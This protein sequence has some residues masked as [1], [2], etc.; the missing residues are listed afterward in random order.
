MKKVVLGAITAALLAI[1][2]TAAPASAGTSTA[3]G[4]PLEK[5]QDCAAA[6]AYGLRNALNGTPQPG[7]C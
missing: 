2:V 4:D 7:S 3:A 1:P 5:V 6:A